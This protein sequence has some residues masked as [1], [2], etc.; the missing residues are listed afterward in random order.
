[1]T[2]NSPERMDEILAMTTSKSADPAKAAKLAQD[3]VAILVGEDSVTRQRSIQAAMLLLGEATP[4]PAVDQ[5]RPVGGNGDVDNEA[6]LVAFFNREGDM[7]PADYVQLCAA[8]HY[9]L[10]GA[11]AFPVTELKTI[12]AN[13]GVVLPDRADM[14]LRNAT[15]K[16]KKLFQPSGSGAFKPTAAGCLHFAEKWK[17]KPGRRAKPSATKGG[18]DAED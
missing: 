18:G 9:S 15:Q 14:T 8:Y 10:Y 12:A 13:A 2:T 5:R 4:V 11:C 7:K 17:V 3:I 16:G 6:D 1:M